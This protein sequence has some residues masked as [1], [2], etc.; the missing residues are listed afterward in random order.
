MKPI[1]DLSEQE[2]LTDSDKAE[3][4]EQTRIYLRSRGRK[5]LIAC[6]AF[7]L[8]CSVVTLFLEGFP[9]HH[10]F[11]SFGRFFLLVTMTMLPVT[12][13]YVGLLWSAWAYRR[14]VEKNLQDD[15]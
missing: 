11:Y 6:I 4:S 1:Y 5:A 8:S 14:D 2:T 12:T 10:Y 13:V 15:Q 7:V 9:L 3:I